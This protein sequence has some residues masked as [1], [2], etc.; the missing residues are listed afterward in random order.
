MDSFMETGSD[1]MSRILAASPRL[2]S[3]GQ[4]V[5]DHAKGAFSIG[6]GFGLEA[7][8]SQVPGGHLLAN[9]AKQMF[10]ADIPGGFTLG[11]SVIIQPAGQYGMTGF[12][13]TSVPDGAEIYIAEER[14]CCHCCCFWMG[15]GPTFHFIDG[16]PIAGN[17]MLLMQSHRMCCCASP[18]IDVMTT[19][20]E[21]VAGV[22]DNGCCCC[23]TSTSV[24]VRGN[25]EYLV[26]SSWYD[27]LTC[28]FRH[29][30][31]PVNGI[32]AVGKISHGCG[33]TTIDFPSDA[34][35]SDKAAIVAASLLW[36]LR[37]S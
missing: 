22:D 31:M 18:E 23:T 26:T 11:S 28:G 16:N 4:S 9:E 19:E 29:S 8:A 2:A 36:H 25:P 33:A 34:R 12:R 37:V 13:M 5:M 24:D 3:T 27:M 20:G 21:L 17:D 10:K 30:I 15:P 1:G 14:G 6:S 7:V 32:T 35:S